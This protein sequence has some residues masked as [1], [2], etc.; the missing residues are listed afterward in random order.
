[1]LLANVV[2]TYAHYVGVFMHNL[3]KRLAS[4]YFLYMELF[5]SI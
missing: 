2:T 1:M 4:N 3:L 5:I